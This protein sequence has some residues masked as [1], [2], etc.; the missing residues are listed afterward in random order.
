MATEPECNECEDREARGCVHCNDDLAECEQCGD[1][2]ERHDLDD[3]LVCSECVQGEEDS[4]QMVSDY[5]HSV[6]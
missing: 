3:N 1:V 6:L 5:R 4:R 2:L